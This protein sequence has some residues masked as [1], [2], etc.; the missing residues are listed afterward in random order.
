DDDYRRALTTADLAIADSGLMVLLWKILRHQSVHRNSGL[1]YL[2]QL[3][4]EPSFLRARASFFVLPTERSKTKTLNWSRNES[5]PTTP[6][7]CYVAPQYG[8]IVQ[9]RQLL[10]LIDD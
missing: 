10:A 6:D 1:A 5:L 4:L 7:G 9:D 8:S 3:L 2:K